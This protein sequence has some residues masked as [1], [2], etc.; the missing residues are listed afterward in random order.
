MPSCRLTVFSSISTTPRGSDAGGG[1]C[2]AAEEGGLG[3]E[4]ER[5]GLSA[6]GE[7]Q[8]RMFAICLLLEIS[9]RGFPFKET[10]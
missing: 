3:E 9:I 4:S 1:A 8:D 10:L 7:E 6:A 2:H 5:H